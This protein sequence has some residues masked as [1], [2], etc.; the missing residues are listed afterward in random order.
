LAGI[1]LEHACIYA[2]VGGF[3]QIIETKHFESQS[4]ETRG[5]AVGD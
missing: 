4:S 1:A 2:S 3:Q 5:K